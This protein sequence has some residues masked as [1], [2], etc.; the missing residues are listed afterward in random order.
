MRGMI[1]YTLTDADKNSWFIRRLQEEGARH[2]HLLSLYIAE[3]KQEEINHSAADFCINRSRHAAF[4]TL[5]ENAGKLSVNN[6]RTIRIANDKWRSFQLFQGLSLPCMPTFLPGNEPAFPF[7]AKS[8]SGHGGSEVFLVK[9]AQ[10]YADVK[11]RLKGGPYILQPLCDEPG[12][13]VRAYVMGSEVFAAVRRSCTTD[14]RSNYSLGGQVELFTL[15]KEQLQ[16]IRLVQKALKS[17]Y[18]GVDFIR[19]QGRWQVNEIED[20]AGARMLY[21]LTDI[22]FIHLF[23]QQIEHKLKEADL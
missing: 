19:H 15:N 3:N 2:G 8:R 11:K 17:D 20:A 4:S 13:D 16:A 5:F 14:F 21:Q 10:S 12:V 1:L 18:I 23:W 6:S 7:V 22:D 9:D